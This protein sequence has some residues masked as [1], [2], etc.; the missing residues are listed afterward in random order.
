M[1]HSQPPTTESKGT[2]CMGI[3]MMEK[4]MSDAMYLI[5]G[6]FC[7]GVDAIVLGFYYNRGSQPSRLYHTMIK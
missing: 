2:L 7:E 5:F 3:V 4:S 1:M 6:Y